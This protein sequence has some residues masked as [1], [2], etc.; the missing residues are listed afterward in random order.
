MATTTTVQP[1]K[2]K[3]ANDFAIPFSIDWVGLLPFL[4]F[5]MVFLILPA[6][7]IVQRALTDGSGAVTLNNLLN[8]S[9]PTIAQAYRSTILVS[10]LTSISGGVIGAGLAW[11]ITVGN[12]PAWIRNAVL[13]FSGVAANFAGLPLV[14]AFVALLGRV[15]LLNQLL[16][17]TGVAI[18]P[19][20]F[21]YGFWGLVIVYTYFQIPLLV[22]IM[23][24]ALDGL[25]REWVE[26]SQ[27]LGATRLQYWRYVGVPILMPALLGAL[28]LLFANAFSTYVTASAL[29][30]AVGQTFAITIV[31][32]NQFRTDTF[33][34]PGLGYALAFSMIL[35]IA[36]TVMI[37]T[38]SRNRAERWLRRTV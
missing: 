26:A 23:V 12:L 31:V 18:D 28:A 38:Y 16:R 32:A 2:R 36:I 17:P 5:V 22:L 13:S 20:T 34:D 1:L 37:Y 4:A 6:W 30:G 14:F 27:N 10:I 33:G 24:P 35:V 9:N 19:Q 29:L 7:S 8:L 3:R 11:A 21:L 15:G 25:R